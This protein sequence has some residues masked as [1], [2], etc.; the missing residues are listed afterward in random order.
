MNRERQE[1]N[2]KIFRWYR[3][4]WARYTQRDPIVLARGMNT[5][6]GYAA[7]NPLTYFDLFGLKVCR[8]DPG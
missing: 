4:G 6:I 7:A 3:S 2:Y 5:C 1:E 8:C